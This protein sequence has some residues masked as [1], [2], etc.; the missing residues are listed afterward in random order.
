MRHGMLFALVLVGAFLVTAVASVP[1]S[2]A[3]KQAGLGRAGLEWSRAEGTIWNG[4]LAGVSYRNQPVGDLRLRLRGGDLVRGALRFDLRLA[5]P[6]V[7]G[8]SI[9]SFPSLSR[10]ALHDLRLDVEMD[11]LSALRAELREAGGRLSLT[12]G[13]FLVDRTGC[14]QGHARVE[15]NLATRFAARFGETWS[16]LAGTARCEGRD[17]LVS[18]SGQGQAQETL[19]VDARLASRAVGLEVRVG[20]ASPRLGYG[21][22]LMGF[23]SEAGRYV[24]RWPQEAE[25]LNP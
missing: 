3:V 10:V 25:E 12:G 6:S 20:S 9:A 8:R 14:L 5:G 16:A 11:R 24:Y 2:A 7:R 17:V 18:L 21:L 23:R 22:G 19:E 1:L 4:R 15:T 13:D